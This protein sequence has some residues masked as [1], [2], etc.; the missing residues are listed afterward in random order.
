[1]SSF[2]HDPEIEP[3]SY[4]VAVTLD[5]RELGVARFVIRR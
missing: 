3:G 1:M 2:I 5:G 4:R